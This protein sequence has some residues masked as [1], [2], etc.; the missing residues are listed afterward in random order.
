M[1]SD[2]YRILV[3]FVLVFALTVNIVLA[4]TTGK[5]AGRVVDKETNEPLIGINVVVK[6]TS[7][8]AATDIDGY[9]A[10]LS[11][12]PGI[13]TIITSMVGYATV[14]VNEIRVLID[15]T[16][17]VNVTM[18]SQAIEAGIVEV[19][20][21]R[22]IVKKDVSTSVAAMQRKKFNPF[23]FPPLIRLWACKRELR[24]VW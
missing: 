19:I 3:Y 5:I 24:M 8:G 21:E 2:R 23:L 6:G 7:L 22:N 1:S 20:A 10:I 14:T 15:Q 12:P 4:G 16:A 17:T 18:V 9:Y 11:V 13:H